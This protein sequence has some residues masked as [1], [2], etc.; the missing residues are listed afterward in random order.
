MVFGLVNARLCWMGK[1]MTHRKLVRRQRKHD[2]LRL[3]AT[4][5]AGNVLFVHVR[6]L[7]FFFLG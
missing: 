5:A 1:E 3:R 4:K 6:I 7:G 2:V